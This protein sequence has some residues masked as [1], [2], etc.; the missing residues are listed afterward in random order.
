M[1]APDRWGQFSILDGRARDAAVAL[2][3]PELTGARVDLMSTLVETEEGRGAIDR[4][5][6]DMTVS[7]HR[8]LTAIFTSD[9]DAVLPDNDVLNPVAAGRHVAEGASDAAHD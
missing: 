9:C 8:I 4:R 1:T 6:G 3:A 2:T 5:G 7:G